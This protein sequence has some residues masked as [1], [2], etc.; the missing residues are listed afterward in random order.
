MCWC[1][2]EGPT[3][4][5]RRPGSGSFPRGGSGASVA[6]TRARSACLSLKLL[7][8]LLKKSPCVQSSHT[9]ICSCPALQLH[10]YQHVHVCASLLAEGSGIPLGIREQVKPEG[11]VAAG[12]DVA[13][14]RVGA[15][16]CETSNFRE[17][18]AE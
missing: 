16:S 3:T 8:K 9:Q 12:A 2:R 4:A 17:L 18:I 14:Q 11:I 5:A 10:T 6:M 13:G 1:S 7:V 15:R